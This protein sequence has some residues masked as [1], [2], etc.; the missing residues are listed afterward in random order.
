MMI[1]NF[2]RA[3]L[4]T[5]ISALTLAFGAANAY[6]LDQF[7]QHATVQGPSGTGLARFTL[8]PEAMRASQHA[9]YADLAMFNAAGEPVPYAV[10]QAE[11]V[12]ANAVPNQMALIPINIVREGTVNGGPPGNVMTET[13]LEGILIERVRGQS[14]LRVTVTAQAAAAS[15][16]APKTAGRGSQMR[17]YAVLGDAVPATYILFDVANEQRDFAVPVQIEASDDLVRWNTIADGT[18]YRV[19]VGATVRESLRIPANGRTIRF[20]RITATGDPVLTADTLQGVLVEQPAS[21]AARPESDAMT[22]AMRAGAEPGEWIADFGG[23]FPLVALQMSLPQQNTI[24]STQWHVRAHS[25]DPWRPLATETVY[26]L[27]NKKIEIRNPEVAVPTL[28]VREVK[29]NVD[30]RGG[31]LGAGEVNLS[32]RYHP[33]EVLFAARGNGPFTLGV[34][35]NSKTIDTSGLPV[36]SIVPGWSQKTRA[37]I[38]AV[39]AEPLRAN[40]SVKPT[41]AVSPWGTVDGR[42][43]ILWAVLFLAVAVLGFMAYRLSRANKTNVHRN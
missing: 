20:V 10:I 27:L 33:I 1:V 23:R 14:A 26:R 28:P 36:A 11:P 4:A 7:N 5:V 12:A 17:H 30:M 43:L 42:K 6:T 29:I 24:A 9:G 31:G 25:A 38:A 41:A 13:K 21:A 35:L 34:G 32:A 8:S 2:Y 40:A 18:I 15:N 3:V 19:Q 16:T 22:I 39:G 37:E